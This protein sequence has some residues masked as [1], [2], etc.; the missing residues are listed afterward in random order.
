MARIVILTEGNSRP[1]DAKTACGVLRYRGDEVVALI[2]STQAGKTTEEVLGIGGD[3]PIVAAIEDVENADTLLIGIAPAG[4]QLPPSWMETI[5]TAIQRGMTIL[6]GL[7]TFLADDPELADLAKQ[8]G[9]E[10]HDLRRVPDDLTVARNIAKDTPCFR[11]H[12]VGLDCNSGKMSTAMEVD[13]GL[14][15][16]GV[17]SE[18]VATGQTGILISG[19]GIAVDRVISDFLAGATERMVVEHQDADFLIVE[20]QGALNHPAYSGVTLGLLHGCA[21]QAMIFCV[22]AGRETVYRYNVTYPPTS[23]LMS[24]FEQMAGYVCPSKVI[25]FSVNTSSLDEDD[26]RRELESLEDALQRPAADPYRFGVD[27]LV[28]AVL[29]ARDAHTGGA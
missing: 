20:G 17:N 7:H 6:S 12:T 4:G 8:H 29:A 1:L 19:W 14:R 13:L 18:F 3:T 27:P 22:P 16:R 21:P 24:L 15:K 5:R 23:E 2:D 11:V 26:A 28:D 9:V 10:I 25:G